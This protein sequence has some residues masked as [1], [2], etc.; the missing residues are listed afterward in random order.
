[1]SR[2]VD[3]IPTVN[4]LLVM[5]FCLYRISGVFIVHYDPLMECYN[6]SIR[7]SHEVYNTPT[8]MFELHCRGVYRKL[9]LSCGIY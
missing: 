3:K 8:T 1:M 9:R 2:K 5:L 6:I 7:R 4:L